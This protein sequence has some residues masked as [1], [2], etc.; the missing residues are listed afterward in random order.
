MADSVPCN[1]FHQFPRATAKLQIPGEEVFLRGSSCLWGWLYTRLSRIIVILTS[2]LLFFQS[3]LFFFLKGTS[4]RTA[5]FMSL[6]CCSSLRIPGVWPQDICVQNAVEVDELKRS[7]TG[8]TGRVWVWSS[9]IKE[10]CL[11]FLAFHLPEHYTTK[12]DG[13]YVTVTETLFAISNNFTKDRT[14]HK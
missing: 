13:W 1:C 5:L 6:T 4:G 2:H 3:Y 8:I 9:T 12:A 10:P 11:E 7:N 14:W